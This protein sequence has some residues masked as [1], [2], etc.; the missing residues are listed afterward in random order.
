[1]YKCVYFLF[2][3]PFFP[4]FLLS[5][6]LSFFLFLPNASRMRYPAGYCR[7]TRTGEGTVVAPR[8]PTGRLDST[9]P[10]DAA[11]ES[12]YLPRL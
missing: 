2:Y 8:N 11:A 9:T 3:F 7:E 4:S 10:G 12:R 6:F 5:F 1:M